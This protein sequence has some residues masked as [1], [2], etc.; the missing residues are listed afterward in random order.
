MCIFTNLKC[1]FGD[2]VFLQIGD[3][4][5]NC[6]HVTDLLRKTDNLPYKPDV[7]YNEMLCKIISTEECWNHVL[8]AGSVQTYDWN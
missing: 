4:I 8:K 6:N 3:N 2:R 5:K 1:F 7:T